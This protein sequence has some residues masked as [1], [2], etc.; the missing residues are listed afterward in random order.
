MDWITETIAIGNHLDVR[1]LDLLRSAA[2]G[3]ILG[4]THTLDGVEPAEVGVKQIRIV[5]LEDGPGNERHRFRHAVDALAELVAEAP[6]VLVH[7]HAG[8]S[9]SAVLVAA[10]LMRSR[11]LRSEDALALIAARREIAVSPVLLRLLDD[12]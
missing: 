10:H 12:L 4:L 8:R 1:N 9:R 3:S 6:P 11:G 7:C 2:I 5:P